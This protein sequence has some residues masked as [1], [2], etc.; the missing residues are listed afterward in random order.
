MLEASCDAIQKSANAAINDDL[1]A[2]YF[3]HLHG[4]ASKVDVGCS[5]DFEEFRPGTCR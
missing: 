1:V 3:L 4:A 2:L 5:K